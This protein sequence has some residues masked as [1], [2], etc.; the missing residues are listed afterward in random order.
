MDTG[1]NFSTVL[2]N[3]QTEGLGPR[4][5]HVILLVGNAFIVC[6]AR[7]SPYIVRGLN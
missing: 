3:T 4:V 6:L 2:V 7:V 1:L 5:G